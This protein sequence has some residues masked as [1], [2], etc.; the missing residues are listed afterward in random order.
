MNQS[1][2]QRGLW[3]TLYCRSITV[4]ATILFTLGICPTAPGQLTVE[5][6]LRSTIEEPQAS[7]FPEIGQAIR[8]FQQNNFQGARAALVE[9][10]EGND[11]LAPA[12][13]MMAQLYGSINQIN[14]LR[15]S[16][17]GAVRL[18][19]EDPEAFIVFGDVA[20]SQGRVTE[21]DLAYKQAVSLCEGYS[22]N[23]FRKSRMQ[24]RAYGGA[25]IVAESRQDWETAKQNLTK[26]S[27]FSPNEAAPLLRLGQVEYRLGEGS[28]EAREAAY[29][30]Y[31]QAY[32]LDSQI[33][34]PE[35]N[36]AR[37]FHQDDNRRNAEHMLELAV[38]RSDH[39]LKTQLEA[40]QLYIAMNAVDS[41]KTCTE[42]ARSID[43]NSFDAM[44]LQGLVARYDEDYL[45]AESAFRDAHS[46]APTNVT[47]M[48]QLALS[49]V[50]QADD[51][52]KQ[53][54]ALDWARLASGVSSDLKQAQ[55]R[56][57]LT[58][59]GWVLDRL[60]RTNEAGQAIQRAV[61]GGRLGAESTFFAAKILNDGGRSEVAR[62]LLQQV[63]D[64]NTPFPYRQDAEALLDRI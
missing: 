33:T 53:S 44:L 55:A 37:L 7:Q 47:V 12:D 50:E 26:W 45:S 25:A 52:R 3:Q 54:Q 40:G 4:I 63:I 64:G 18:H 34:R 32:E 35:I 61:S 51:Q 1:V 59:L 6:L 24:A 23:D 8:D 62:Q 21:A 29:N 56:E 11:Q 58:T 14:A 31:R 30:A 16:L 42:K 46:V 10:A 60:G 20:R 48:I 57:A 27:E 39:D 41:A 5:L 22:N 28:K 19:P 17:E 43:E 36:M 49:L 15:S 38:E 9:A 2:Q 13:V